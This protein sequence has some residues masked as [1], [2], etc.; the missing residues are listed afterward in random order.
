[1]AENGKI[2]V[3]FL[4]PRS[5]EGFDA[6]IG[7]NTTG[8]QAIAGLLQ[9]KFLESPSALQAYALQHVRTA[10]QLPVSASLIGEGV[11]AGDQINVLLTNAG[12]GG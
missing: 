6:Q 5:S 12:A 2:K 1:M 4:H 11:T 7:A 8:Q 10:K 3:T 9:E